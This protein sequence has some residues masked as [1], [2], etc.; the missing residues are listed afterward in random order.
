MAVITLSTEAAALARV[1][2]FFGHD[3]QIQPS[4]FRMEKVLSADDVDHEFVLT[5]KAQREMERTLGK[6][7]VAVVYAMGVFLQKVDKTRTTSNANSTNYSYPDKAVFA[8]A[9]TVTGV[10]EADALESIYNG[11]VD[12]KIDTFEAIQS[13]SLQPYRVVPEIQASATT[14]ASIGSESF[15]PFY[16]VYA[17]QGD[18]N[19]VL[20]FKKP[21]KSN[22]ENIGG[23]ADEE[24]VMSIVMKAFIV[25]NAAKKLT[26]MNLSA[27]QL[28][29]LKEGRLLS[30]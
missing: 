26:N 29:A 14:Q 18:S 6:N 2:S 9:A 19:I 27:G 23:G 16:N 4:Y 28:Q 22:T 17:L 25:R 1:K 12:M 15:I 20:N 30:A 3:A 8:T 10:S 11:T 21:A 13:M 5:D 7:D 24:N